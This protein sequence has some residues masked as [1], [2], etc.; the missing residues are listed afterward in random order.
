M[1]GLDCREGLKEEQCVEAR[2][3]SDNRKRKGRQLSREAGQ[4][5]GLSCSERGRV[6]E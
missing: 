4:G 1:E 6:S 2:G 5:V 3:L